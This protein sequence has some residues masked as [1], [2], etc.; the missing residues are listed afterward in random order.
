MNAGL[1]E[2]AIE[3]ARHARRALL[4]VRQVL[5]GPPIAQA[6]LCIKLCALIVKAMTDLMTDDDADAAV[7]HRIDS[8]VIKGWWLQNSGWE[9]DRI[10]QRVVARIRG[11]RCLV[12]AAPVSGL[13]DQSAVVAD[14]P[15]VRGLQV[16]PEIAP[17]KG[18]PAVAF[19]FVRVADVRMQCG[20]LCQRLLF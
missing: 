14:V 5:R 12:E 16:A 4:K 20:E 3:L 19:P 2:I 17:N 8:V 15:G 13:A 9:E 7:V 18:Q 11:R 6:P 10:Q 1:D